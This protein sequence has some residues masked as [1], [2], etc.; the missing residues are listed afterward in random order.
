M[1]H[2]VVAPR[3]SDHDW[4]LS[5]DS[6]LGRSPPVVGTLSPWRLLLVRKDQVLR[7]AEQVDDLRY[8]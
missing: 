4:H 7:E 2:I 3:D 6:P 5:L 1:P 8:G